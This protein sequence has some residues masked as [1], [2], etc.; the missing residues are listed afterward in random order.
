MGGLMTEE[1]HRGLQS[2]VKSLVMLFDS[3][4]PL[5]YLSYSLWSQVA[6]AT[7]FFQIV[8]KLN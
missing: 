7:S 5:S 1:L 2:R 6:A 8:N 3:S 4:F